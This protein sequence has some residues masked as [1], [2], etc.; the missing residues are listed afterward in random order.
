MINEF[1]M[2]VVV[3]LGICFFAVGYELGKDSEKEKEKT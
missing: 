1:V 3:L 2:I